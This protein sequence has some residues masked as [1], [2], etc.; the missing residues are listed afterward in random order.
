M[1]IFPVIPAKAGIQSLTLFLKAR[2]TSW[3]PAFAGVTIL[4]SLSAPLHAAQKP[5][6]QKFTFSSATLTCD[7][8]EY[9]STEGVIDARGNA[10]LVSS[11]A[12]LMADEILL[13]VSS[14]T[15]EARGH[16]VAE[17]GALTIVAEEA[18]FSQ[19]SSEGVFI[20]GYFSDPP[21]RIWARRIVRV[22]TELYHME[23]A[24]VTSCDEDPPHYHVR[25]ARLDYR[26]GVG[27]TAVW[28]R[29]VLGRDTLLGFPYYHKTFGRAPWTL[30]I[31]PGRSSY[32]GF[33]TKTIFGYRLTEN[34]T[35]R[36]YW[37][38]FTRTGEGLGAEY[39]YHAPS[40]QG[41]VY[42]YKV[43]DRIAGDQRWN[44]RVVHWEQLAP[45]LS[46]QINALAQSD[47]NFNNLYF[48][49]DPSRVSTVN[50]SN[51]S[52]AYQTPLYSSRL[53]VRDDQVFDTARNAFVRQTTVLPELSFQ[54]SPWKAPG[55]SYVTFAA[56][57]RNEYDRP[58]VSTAPDP[59]YGATDFFRRTGESSVSL[60][61]PFS[62][63]KTMTLEPS[64]GLSE[65]WESWQGTTETVRD[66]TDAF[67]GRVF[68]G[69]NFR[70]RVTRNFDYDLSHIYRIRWTPNEF[71]RDRTNLTDQGAES[72]Q[73]GLIGNYRLSTFT[74]RLSTGYD[75]RQMDGETLLTPRRKV[76]PPALDLSWRPSRLTSFS[77]R[78]VYAVYPSRH[79][80]TEQFS[81]RT[82]RAAGLHF[83]SGFSYNVG[84]PGSVTIRHGAAFPLTP[85]W[86]VQ[87]DV[88]YLVQGGTN[89]LHY[90]SVPKERFEQRYILKR[91]LHCWDATITFQK[92]PGFYEAFVRIELKAQAEKRKQMQSPDEDQYY[93]GR[94]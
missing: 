82:G 36:L 92:R 2:L 77:Y 35:A 44:A 59:I 7:F 3:A 10:V 86:W 56:A 45:R 18:R 47:S 53:T 14:R 60:S 43:S 28:P 15:A 65:S 69:L 13:H 38:H 12:R 83:S 37:D 66:L 74:G 67:Q 54:G 93:P 81:W 1:R 50:P 27:A 80:E 25:M 71:K 90:D 58:V 17:E 64:A 88:S 49:D 5:P 24:A 31:D 46:L 55:G 26:P 21:Y 84:L 52:V 42:G 48:K 68:T 11:A 41:S 9:R 33:Y 73:L 89:G 57:V 61:R 23:H 4:L 75:L 79:A 8:L 16:V 78:E 19:D 62:L 29:F 40:V 30:T 76:V 91:D 72:N 94:R 22:S 70:Q 51:A 63:G 85:G 87:G 32:Q 34:G 39:T 6:L 20:N